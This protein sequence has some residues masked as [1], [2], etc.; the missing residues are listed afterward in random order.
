MASAH[1]MLMRLSG[2]SGHARKDKLQQV[3]LFLVPKGSAALAW[4]QEG[5]FENHQSP[6]D[7]PATVH[8][9]AVLAE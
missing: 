6:Q 1:V 2:C 4:G 5:V 8:A 3:L 9:G 7:Q